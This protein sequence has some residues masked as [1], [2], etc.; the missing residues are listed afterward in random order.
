MNS[1]KRHVDP[2]PDEFESYEEAAAFWDTHDTTDYLELF[3]T[4]DV[5]AKLRRRH[6]EIEVEEDVMMAVRALTKK[7]GIT[8]SRLVNDILRQQILAGHS[9]GASG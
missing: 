2:V 6:Y 3:E 9:A 1:T 5:N 7:R 8:A 4:V